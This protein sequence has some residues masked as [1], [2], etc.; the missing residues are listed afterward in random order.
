MRPRHTIRLFMIV[1]AMLFGV[2]AL[3]HRGQLVAGY[4]HRQAQ[5]AESVLAAVLL[6]GLLLIW[7][8]P[9][10][11]R[12]VGVAAQGFALL[13]TLVGVF[14]IIVGVGPRTTLDIVYH[15]VLVALL[16]GGV[17]AAVRS[18]PDDASAAGA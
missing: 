10:W 13:G 15:A 11:T 18:R 5:T 9:N 2:A 7:L 12:A 1:E 14:T 8:R 17:L 16:L 3:V 4:E 6:I